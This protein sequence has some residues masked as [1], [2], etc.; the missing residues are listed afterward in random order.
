MRAFTLKLP[1][2]YNTYIYD[3]IS[4]MICNSD[5]IDFYEY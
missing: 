3:E 4:H 5:K 1:V 2:I